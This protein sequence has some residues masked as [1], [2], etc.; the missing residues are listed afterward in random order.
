M[1]KPSIEERQDLLDLKAFLSKAP[2][3]CL[4]S[5]EELLELVRGANDLMAIPSFV[6]GESKAANI[7]PGPKLY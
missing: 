2:G 1:I 3:G 4:L 6:V 5:D 7:C